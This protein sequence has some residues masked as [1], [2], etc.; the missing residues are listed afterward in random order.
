[1]GQLDGA[2]DDNIKGLGLYADNVFLNGSLTTK[3]DQDSYAGV[4][5][6]G[7]ANAIVF[8]DNDKSRIVFW[9]GSASSSN[10]DIQNAPF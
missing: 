4:N 5:T 6:I 10:I 1:L 2:I 7:E 9:A 3:V 8:E